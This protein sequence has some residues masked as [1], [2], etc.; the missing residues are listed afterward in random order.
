MNLA[1]LR[2]SAD[3]CLWYVVSGHVKDSPK[4]AGALNWDTMGQLRIQE[5]GGA[6][7]TGPAH[8]DLAWAAVLAPHAPLGS[9]A[10]RAGN[11]GECGGSATASAYLEGL[12]T[13][14]TGTTPLI[15]ASPDS[16]LAGINNDQAVWI[17]GREVFAPIE[18]RA[19]FKADIDALMD[20]L[21]AELN[22]LPPHR[23]PLTGATAKGVDPTHLARFRRTLPSQGFQRAFLDHWQDQLLFAGGPGGRYSVNGSS[24]P[25]R[26]VLLFGGARRQRTVAPF[27][28][29]T[30]TSAVEKEDATMYLEEQ[31]AVIFPADGAYVGA[32]AV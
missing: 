4:T 19:D 28:P 29:Q 9:Q 25:C 12:G 14:G 20:G 7:P 22:R 10:R 15:V 30:R 3:E 32:N 17:T 8:T 23:L 26:A 2:D 18:R 27:V 31:N 13:L 21:A 1:P 5:A 11:A 6:T 24:T 16:R